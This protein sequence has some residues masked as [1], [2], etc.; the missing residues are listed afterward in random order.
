MDAAKTAAEKTA[1]KAMESGKKIAKDAVDK[2]KAGCQMPTGTD[3]AAIDKA[4]DDC[5]N[6]AVGAAKDG[7]HDVVRDGSLIVTQPLCV[8]GVD[9]AKAGAGEVANEAK[10]KAGPIAAEAKTKAEAQAATAK[11]T[12]EESAAIPLVL[13][14]FIYVLMPCVCRKPRTRASRLARKWVHLQRRQ[15]RRQWRLLNF[16]QLRLARRASAST[17]M[18]TGTR[19]IWISSSSAWTQ[20]LLISGAMRTM[21]GFSLMIC[22][23]LDVGATNCSTSMETIE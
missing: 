11:Q 17:A 15:A 3:K 18:H 21:T 8:A 19:S 9:E 1:K 20:S 23:S 2:V 10:E 16:S 6:A 12:M 22:R 7:E 5:K 13:E 4:V 14:Q